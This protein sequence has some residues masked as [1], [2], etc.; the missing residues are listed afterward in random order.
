MKYFSLYCFTLTLV[1]PSLGD[2]LNNGLIHSNAILSPTSL[3]K[4]ILYSRKKICDR[5]KKNFLRKLKLIVR[6][7]RHESKVAAAGFQ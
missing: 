4:K 6:E 1:P 7:S 5:C 2:S 3:L